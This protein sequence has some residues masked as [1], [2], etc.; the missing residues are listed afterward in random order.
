M[1][2]DAVYLNPLANL[3]QCYT[4]HEKNWGKQIVILNTVISNKV[5]VQSIND[6]ALN[7]RA[8]NIL[9]GNKIRL[10]AVHSCD[11]AHDEIPETSFQ[12]RN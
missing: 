5:K 10:G 3:K 6:A 9:R 1:V 7:T 2:C 4:P 12:G 11:D 8:S